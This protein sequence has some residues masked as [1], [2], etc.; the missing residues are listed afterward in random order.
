MSR[1]GHFEIPADDPERL[2]AFYRDLLGW[3]IEKTPGWD[4]WACKTGDGPGID[5]AITRKSVVAG[6]VNNVTV[7]EID[8]YLLLAVNLGATVLVERTAIPGH[9]WY[10]LIRDPEGNP[11]G[12]WQKDEAAK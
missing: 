1:P 6:P 7:D 3:T 5:G 9:G 8:R 2:V 12:F 4:Y 10:A 11:L